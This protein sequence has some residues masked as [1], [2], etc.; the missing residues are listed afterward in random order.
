MM[1]EVLIMSLVFSS[2]VST[3]S[4][5]GSHEQGR[6]FFFFVCLFVYFSV[7][8]FANGNQFNVILIPSHQF[9]PPNSFSPKFSECCYIILSLVS[10]LS[11]LLHREEEN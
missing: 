4:Y 10:A 9:E 1:I 5:C 7:T 8:Y 6:Q 11:A 3:T 2:P